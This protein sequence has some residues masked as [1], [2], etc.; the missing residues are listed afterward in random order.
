MV[1]HADDLVVPTDG[2]LFTVSVSA[3]ADSHLQAP[4]AWVCA[5][6]TEDNPNNRGLLPGHISS[7][8]CP[9]KFDSNQSLVLGKR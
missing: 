4:K 7:L 6:S 3:V 1:E 9:D 2:L 8:Q 5:A